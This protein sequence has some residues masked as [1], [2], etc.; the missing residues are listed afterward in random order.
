VDEART[1]TYVPPGATIERR[2]SHLLMDLAP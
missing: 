2:G 1:V